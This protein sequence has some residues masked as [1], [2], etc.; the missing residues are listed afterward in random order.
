[1]KTI[2]FLAEVDKLEGEL[3]FYGGELEIEY[4]VIKFIK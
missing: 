1:M 2:L 3:E 4:K